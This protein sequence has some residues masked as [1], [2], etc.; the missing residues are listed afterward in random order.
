KHSHQGIGK[1]ISQRTNTV[2]IK[3]IT[4]KE[5]SFGQGA[6]DNDTITH[7]RLEIG[8]DCLA[9]NG[10]CKITRVMR[11]SHRGS[12]YQYQ[13]IYDNG[14]SAVVSEFDLTPLPT[15]IQQDP[16]MQFAS[17]DP[18]AYNVFRSRERL[19][20]NYSQML[21]EGAGLR[22]LLSSRIDLRP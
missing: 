8:T 20:D 21:R 7:A 12:P 19:V 4:G 14:M 6:F 1:V 18:Q 15:E 16:L 5:L 10:A 22:A 17:L 2:L 13:V 11:E 9:E 3:F